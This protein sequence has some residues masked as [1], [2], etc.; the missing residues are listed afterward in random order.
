MQRTVRH[1]DRRRAGAIQRLTSQLETL[2]SEVRK[3]DV[4]RKLSK[5]NSCHEFD[6]A[7]YKEKRQDLISKSERVKN[8]IERTRARLGRNGW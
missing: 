4:S 2:D 3:M 1:S 8:E 5:K 7:A 6:E